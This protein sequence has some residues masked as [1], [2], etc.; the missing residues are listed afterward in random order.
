MSFLPS[1][2]SPAPPSRAPSLSTRPHHTPVATPCRCRCRCR[3]LFATPF[4]S[5]KVLDKHNA[6]SQCAR[7]ITL[8]PLHPR[9]CSRPRCVTHHYGQ[10]GFVV[11]RFHL[12]H[13][14][15]PRRLPNSKSSRVH[16]GH[17]SQWTL[18]RSRK[19]TIKN[20]TLQFY[21]TCCLF[22]NKTGHSRV[23]VHTEMLKYWLS[24]FNAAM[25][26]YHGLQSSVPT[27]FFFF[28]QLNV[29]RYSH[30]FLE[31]VLSSLYLTKQSRET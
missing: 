11:F 28:C 8:R 3:C 19:A 10:S 14:P 16:I 27:F 13:W 25:L 12:T 2:F 26:R 20:Y 15:T 7:D 22:D 30:Q 9:H 23:L 6:L 21:R 31:L 4:P 1:P 29:R 18:L 5:F 17:F 24:H